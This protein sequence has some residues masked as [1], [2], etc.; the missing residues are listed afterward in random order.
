MPKRIGLLEVF[1]GLLML[2]TVA[3]SRAAPTFL[4]GVSQG[5]VSFPELKEA[6]GIVASRNNTD[7]LWTHND[8]GDTARILAIDTH[9][10]KLG[11]YSLPNSSNVDYED[12][13]LGPGPVPNV[14]YLYVG[15]IGDNNA[16]RA[17]IRIY[18]VPEPAVYAWQYS[19]PI[20][21][22]LKGVRAITLTYPDGAHNAEALFVD[23]CSGDL[24]IATKQSMISTIYTVTKAELDAT[25]SLSL[26]YVRS[27]SFDVVSGADI[28]PAG[29]EI[30]FRQEDF[31][32]LWTRTPGQSV[33]DALAGAPVTIP[34]VGRPTE[35]N[36]EAIGF[37]SVG[38]G[39][40]TL[41]DSATNQPL[42]YFARTSADGPRAPRQTVA[43]GSF[44]NYL[45]DGSDQGTA[46][47]NPGFD[48]AIWPAGQGRFGY[49]NGNEQTVVS[50]GPSKTNKYVTTYF[51]T[52][53][54]LHNVPCIESLTLR[55]LV[56]DGAAV[57][58]NGT[59]ALYFQLSTNAA[60][61]TLAAAAQ[62]TNLED[63]WF[64]F[65]ID[66]HLL[67]N[68]TNT[69]A[70]EIHQ[71]SVTS[72][73]LSFDLQLLGMESAAPIFTGAAFLTNQVLQLWLCGP[74][75]S[76]VTIQASQNLTDWTILGGIA[77]TNGTG[78]FQDSQAGDFRRR[79]YRAVR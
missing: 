63:T 34:V 5:T 31:A 48:D 36:G 20:I 74:S 78:S 27:V 51:R 7:V 45:D 37:D 49:G 10:R 68:G 72:S 67:V 40:Y 35:P 44:W 33:S 79:Y 2:I 1:T 55:M 13:G 25:N 12:I 15:D 26:K 64:S 76:S 39:Y 77:M 9:G 65:P 59:P 53:F 70:V 62:A 21:A 19:N 42:Y 17:N 60:H 69:L 32:K 73:N 41:S 56:D 30:V 6:S 47:R 8:S 11:V 46:W 3:R 22:S 23:P 38:S 75:N 24:F 43:A 54:V 16:N 28:S 61:N 58:L 71:A 4:G 18:Q 52:S 57:F 66:P 14:L 50:Y 29:T